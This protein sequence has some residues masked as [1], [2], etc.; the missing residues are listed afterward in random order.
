MAGSLEGKNYRVSD[1]SIV[2]FD[3][4]GAHS[5]RGNWAIG[6]PID[7][8]RETGYMNI[9]VN[10]DNSLAVNEVAEVIQSD[11]DNGREGLIDHVLITNRVAV[12][13]FL[14]GAISPQS[15]RNA[16][17]DDDTI[18]ITA[19]LVG[20]PRKVVIRSEFDESLQYAISTRDAE[21]KLV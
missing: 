12:R 2:L 7:G 10:P 16:T 9:E 21:G 11:I 15:F 13:M 14:Q 4:V 5:G 19:L 8:T 20:K 18:T 17:E 1:K 3:L 6:L